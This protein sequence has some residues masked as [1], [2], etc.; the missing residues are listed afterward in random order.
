MR[1]TVRSKAK[2]RC[3][4]VCM[5]TAATPRT[6]PSTVTTTH[7]VL[8][9]NT[10]RRSVSTIALQCAQALHV[11][12]V[13]PVHREWSRCAGR[14]AVHVVRHDHTVEP[15]WTWRSLT[16]LECPRRSVYQGSPSAHRPGGSADRRTARAQS[17]RAGARR[18]TASGRCS[19][20]SPSF[21][22][23]RSS[24]ALLRLPRASRAGAAAA[25]RFPDD[26]LGSRL[27]NWKMNPILSRR[28]AVS[29]RRTGRRA[30]ARRA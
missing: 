24:R 8:A 12:V 6:M 1:S 27:K 10:A 2:D 19:M 17:P 28:T 23:S 20:R 9:E 25:P 7:R 26:R 30:A 21:T 5:A 22:N 11:K 16:R 18:R 3:L 14:S 4:A 29:H 15:S 13:D